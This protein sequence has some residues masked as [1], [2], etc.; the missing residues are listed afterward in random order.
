MYSWLIRIMIID[1]P[2]GNDIRV[3][4][5]DGHEDGREREEGGFRP[6]VAE[7]VQSHGHVGWNY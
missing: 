5:F 7:R 4:V 3:A 2:C 1:Q 6:L